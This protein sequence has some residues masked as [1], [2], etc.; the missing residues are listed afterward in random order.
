MLN[1]KNGLYFISCPM[2]VAGP[3]PEY[4]T[5]STGNV[6]SFSLMFLIKE[7]CLPPGKSVLPIL[8]RNKA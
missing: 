5:V 8:S 1:Y 2:V 6:S 4:T 7:T 3:W